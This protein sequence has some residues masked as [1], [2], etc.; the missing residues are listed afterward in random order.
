MLKKKHWGPLTGTH[1]A[2]ETAE[3]VIKTV[4]YLKKRA[5]FPIRKSLATLDLPARTYHR[6]ASLSGKKPRPEGVLPKGHWI[7]PEERAKILPFKRQHPTV[8]G[9][10]LSFMMLDQ[11][12]AAVSP[13]TVFRIL[14]EAGLSSQWTLPEGRKASRQGFCQPQRP[15]EQWHTDIAYIK[16]PGNAFLLDQRPGR[17][18]P[19]DRVLGSSDVHD[20]S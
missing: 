18:F 4:T 17:L 7:L 8:G 13:A 2:P 6:W 15:H 16:P 12:V 10:R 14:K 5:G 9:V 11:G 1:V 3:E 19:L 20:H